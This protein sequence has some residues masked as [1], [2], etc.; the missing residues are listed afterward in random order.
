MVFLFDKF[1]RL[2]RF[3][4]QTEKLICQYFILLIREIYGLWLIRFFF[5]QFLNSI[6][7]RIPL[8]V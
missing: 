2:V 1:D 7:N 3:I 8:V 4:E 5:L 6:P